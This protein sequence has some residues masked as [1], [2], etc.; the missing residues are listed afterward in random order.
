MNFFVFSRQA[1]CTDGSLDGDERHQGW[2]EASLAATGGRWRLPDPGVRG[3]E[4]GHRDRE[5]GARRQVPRTPGEAYH[6]RHRPGTRARVQVPSGG[7]QLR[8]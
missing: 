6:R 4:A 5:V 1:W 2:S 3:G 8:R 7:G